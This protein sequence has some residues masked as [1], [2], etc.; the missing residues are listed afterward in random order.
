MGSGLPDHHVHSRYSRCN[1]ET[2]DLFDIVTQLRT[3]NAP[4]YCVSDHI[5]WNDDDEYFPHHLKAAQSLLQ[6][7]LDRPLYLGAE[8][9]MVTRNGRLPR[10]VLSAG[11]LSYFLAGDHYIPGTSITMDDLLGSKRILLSLVQNQPDVLRK[12][13]ATVKQMYL[14]CVRNH[15]P[16]VLVHP[17][18]TFLRC[19][20]THTTL[21]EDWDAVCQACQETGT[22]IELNLSQIELC[23]NHPPSPLC[24]HPDVPPLPDFYRALLRTVAKYDLQYSLGSDAHT[25]P[26]VGNVTQPWA[27]AQEYHLSPKKLLNFLDHPADI[28]PFQ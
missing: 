5:H 18:A 11:K 26:D 9:T 16:H 17:Y 10:H 3:K 21:L 13:L 2:Y 20:F 7:G 15:K 14:G 22:A 8:I 6:K 25:L 19:D 24:A 27:I 28:R 4:Y 23:I 12:V 1:H